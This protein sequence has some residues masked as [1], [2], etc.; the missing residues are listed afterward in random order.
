[1]KID[2][3][4]K[5]KKIIILKNKH[6]YRQM[7]PPQTIHHTAFILVKTLSGFTICDQSTLNYALLVIHSNARLLEKAVFGHFLSH[8][9]SHLFSLKTLPFWESSMLLVSGGLAYFM[10]FQTQRVSDIHSDKT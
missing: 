8:L 6:K 2:Q 3:E 4:I 7:N 5:K 9:F 1:M 10:V